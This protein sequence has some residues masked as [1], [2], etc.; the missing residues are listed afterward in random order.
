MRTIKPALSI[1][2]LGLAFSSCFSPD[3][4]PADVSTIKAK[5]APEL[6]SFSAAN[7]RY[8]KSR[9]AQTP[10]ATVYQAAGITREDLHECNAALQDLLTNID[11]VLWAF[12]KS[13][14][15]L[16]DGESEHW[17]VK[18]RICSLFEN[19]IGLLEENWDTWRIEGLQ[20]KT[21][22][23]QGWQTVVALDQRD[24]EKEQKTLIE[25]HHEQSTLLR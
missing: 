10:N 12:E 2:L 9:W 13:R 17:R 21:G 3:A 18:R 5:L 1:A 25:H 20:P 23:P 19:Q 6:A 15:L 8:E 14:V 24:I 11:L 4:D 22:K 7:A 16:P